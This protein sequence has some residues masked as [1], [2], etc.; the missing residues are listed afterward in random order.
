MA[1]WHN[2]VRRISSALDAVVPP[3]DGAAPP[4]VAV[5]CVTNRPEQ[6]EHVC[7]TI[8][9]QAGVGTLRVVIVLNDEE[10]ESSVFE[11]LL[12]HL[13]LSIVHRPPP[14]SLGVCLN[15]GWELAG[16]RYVAKIDDD[17]V[18]GPHYLRDAVRVL[19]WS[20]AAVVGKHTYLA[21]LHGSA[22]TVLRFPGHEW[23]YS[24]FVAG[25]TI[26]ADTERTGGARFGDSTTGEDSAFLAA[27]EQCGGL[28]LATSPLDFVQARHAHNTWQ[29]DD[30]AFARDALSLGVDDLSVVVA[31]GMTPLDGT[32]I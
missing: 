29:L 22:T 3:L 10:G 4:S 11:R 18:Y 32:T 5:V 23:A 28:V 2:E 17:D 25:G 7:A 1:W 19:R 12:G 16:T 9:R 8:A 13:D 21:R 24:G 20:A 31:S 30:A 6:A 15:T 14:T 26:V 27:V